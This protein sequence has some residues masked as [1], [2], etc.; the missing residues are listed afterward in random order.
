VLCCGYHGW[1]DWYATT[2]NPPK[3]LGIPFSFFGYTRKIEYGDLKEIDDWFIRKETACFI[4]EPMSRQC[5]ERASREYLLEVRRLCDK[6]GVILIFDEVIMGFRYAMGGGGE[7][8]GI[9]PDLACFSKAMANGFPL[10]ALVGERGIMQEIAPLQ[11]SGTFYGE[12]NTIRHCL[13]TIDIMEKNSV[14]EHI[15]RT[16]NRLIEGI[17]ESINVYSLNRIVRLKGMGPW[18][19]LDWSKDAYNYECYFMQE[20][21]KQG[22]FY[23]RDFFL[24]FS[25]TDKEVYITLEAID[26]IFNS[27]NCFNKGGVNVKDY[28]EGRI[29]KSLYPR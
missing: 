9:K 28:L 26:E 8:F 19:S 15:W 1:D 10:A 3:N 21:F 20:I 27:I 18:S 29:D 12:V 22:I 4:L 6:Y 23:N 16:G 2:L 11:V 17:K 25:H 5:P 13:K 24:M 7:Y 14:I